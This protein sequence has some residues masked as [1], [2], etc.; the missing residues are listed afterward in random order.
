MKRVIPQLQKK[1]LEEVLIL[2]KPEMDDLNWRNTNYKI[3][4]DDLEGNTTIHHFNIDHIYEYTTVM[5]RTS[6]W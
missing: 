4:I 2:M 3:Y 1:T 5:E 6:E